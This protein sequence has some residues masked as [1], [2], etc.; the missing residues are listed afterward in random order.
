M[1]KPTIGPKSKAQLLKHR[2]PLLCRC[3]ELFEFLRPLLNGPGE[4]I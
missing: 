4:L 1:R 3:S 2:I